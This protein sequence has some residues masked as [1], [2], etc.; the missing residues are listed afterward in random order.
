[1]V[2]TTG[3]MP[4]ALGGAAKPAKRKPAAKKAAPRRKPATKKKAK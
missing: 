3:S 4:E 2:M 1:M